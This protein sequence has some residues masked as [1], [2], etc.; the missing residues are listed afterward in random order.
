MRSAA[1]I[2]VAPKSRPS[3]IAPDAIN[4]C[5]TRV[6]A[7]T[8]EP[9]L[10]SHDGAITV[11][12]DVGPLLGPLT[13]IGVAVQQ[14][15]A[16]L[17]E[18]PRV[19]LA[20]YACS[21]RGAMPHGTT[22]LPVPAAIAQR[23]WG[24][25]SGP[26]MD[27]WLRPAQVIHGTNYVVPPSRLPRVVSVYD[28]WF[29]RQPTHASG[30][31]VRAG[32]V[33][34]RAVDGG[35]TVHASSHATADAVREL[36]HTD[37]VEVIPLAA[38][39]LPEQPIISIPPVAEL[40]GVPF[41]VAIGTLE[42]RK[43]LPRLVQAFGLI[44]DAHSDLRLVLAGQDGDDRGATNTAI[45]RLPPT[46]RDRV[47]F[48]GRID[49]AAKHWLLA[50]AIVLAYPSLDEGFGFPLLEAMAYD[51]PVVASTAGSI[52][53][54][55]GDAALLVAAHDVHALAD[56]LQLALTDSA[57][58]TRLTDAGRR[59]IQHYSWAD[60]ASQLAGLYRRLAQEGPR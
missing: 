16:T 15:V 30:D 53:E 50:H 48:T 13:G 54:V 55:A 19:A 59:R 29:L 46:T 40:E 42:T 43:N 60:T 10:E 24:R 18:S 57:T 26:R 52:P 58:R 36:L 27:H 39:P 9:H 47:M 14:M 32:R 44:A 21:F 1:T 7:V 2:E 56:A 22:R 51:L 45:D 5:R 11:A 8:A 12:I 17:H 25:L 33:L 20:P 34:R 41:M 38:L 4:R 31:V 28:C 3:L 23:L 37:R 35:A 49:E 6:V